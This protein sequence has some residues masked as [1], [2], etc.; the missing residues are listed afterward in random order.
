MRY[1]R[2]VAA[3]IAR[4]MQIRAE[5]QENRLSDPGSVTAADCQR[6]VDKDRFWLCEVDGR[7]VGFSASDE[8]DGSIW[9]LF[10][11]PAWQGRGIG[12]A[13]LERA[14]AD[15]RA[16]GHAVAR[17]STDPGTRADRM[18]RRLGWAEHGI[19]ADGEVRF[20]RRL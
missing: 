20:V 12:P 13:L 5:V 6:F 11:D 8:R 7:I 18:Y 1:R 15:L 2:G 14:C 3:D 17:L 9:A 19:G 4:I 16:D 10:L